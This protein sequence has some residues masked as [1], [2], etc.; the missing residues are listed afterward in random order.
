MFLRILAFSDIHGHKK[1]LAYVQKMVKEQVPDLVLIAGDATDYAHPASTLELL[2][3]MEC[4][5]FLVPGNMD[6]FMLTGKEKNIKDIHA[7]REVREGIGFTGFAAV[8]WEDEEILTLLRETMSGGDVLLTHFP[9]KGY[10]DLAHSGNHAG[11][12]GLAKAIKEIGPRLVVSGHIHEA[13]GIVNDQGTYYVNPGPA[14]ESRGLL[15]T[16]DENETLI[17][18]L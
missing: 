12:S 17:Q 6:R 5:I 3:S 2:E 18:K 4:E 13:P 10:N 14:Y 7:V 8:L 15:I 1:G 9:P 11:L 16:M